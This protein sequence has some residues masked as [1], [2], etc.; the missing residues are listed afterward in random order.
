M[1]PLAISVKEKR[2][3]SKMVST[4]STAGRYWDE[5]K[6]LRNTAIHDINELRDGYALLHGEELP[7]LL[8]DDTASWDAGESA[9]KL[10]DLRRVLEQGG[11]FPLGKRD[12]VGQHYFTS[13]FDPA[14]VIKEKTRE[15]LK[16]DS[17]S[18]LLLDP[19]ATR[20]GIGMHVQE[21]QNGNRKRL[22][23][24]LHIDRPEDILEREEGEE[25]EG[26]NT[27]SN[28]VHT[29]PMKIAS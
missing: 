26:S 1:N 28:A 5:G 9:G 15:W 29:I 2:L 18:S 24:V 27:H 3:F 10:A 16:A 22:I 20:I 7:A 25:Q 4:N 21:L 12:I 14:N 17:Q 8:L 13:S 6:E 19:D 23:I 11:E